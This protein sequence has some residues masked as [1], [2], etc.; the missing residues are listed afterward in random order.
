MRRLPRMRGRTDCGRRSWRV[1]NNIQGK[2]DSTMEVSEILSRFERFT[3]KFEREAVDAAVAQREEV[4]PELL[5]VLEAIVDP[6]RAFQL[7][8]EEDYMAH[9][10]AMYLLA[11]FRETR[12]F[13]HVLRIAQHDGDLLESLFGDFI[14][15]SLGNV[16]AS[17]CGGEVEEIQSLIENA[18]ADEWVRGAA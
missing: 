15:G 14:T 12:A 6:D 11:Q 3:G 9:L 10:Y 7:D 17:V 1:M 13:P 2:V 4:T 16:L 18:D 5:R 8:A